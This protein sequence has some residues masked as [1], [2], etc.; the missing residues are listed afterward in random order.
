MLAW[1]QRLF[2]IRVG[3]RLELPAAEIIVHLIVTVASLVS[4]EIV[5]LVLSIFGLSSKEIP[6][7]G[8]TLGE[9][10]FYLEVTAASFIILVGIVK[11]V[12]A[13]IRS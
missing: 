8:I 7:T 4:I 12:I 11:A 6:K 5:D 13:L 9:F 2:A 10:M 1:L 3:P